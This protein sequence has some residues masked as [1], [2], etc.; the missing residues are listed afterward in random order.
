MA[1]PT[2][3]RAVVGL[4]GS[5]IVTVEPVLVPRTSYG[6]VVKPPCGRQ[7]CVVVV[8]AAPGAQRTSNIHTVE[9]SALSLIP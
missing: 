3:R 7:W 4:L 2:E 6:V 5:E 8:Q 9:L 1:K